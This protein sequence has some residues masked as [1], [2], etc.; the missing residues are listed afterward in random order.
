[1]STTNTNTTEPE[2]SLVEAAERLGIS[3]QRLR[4][5]V[6]K[7]PKDDRPRTIKAFL[8]GRGRWITMSEFRRFA[9]LP[10]KVGH[11]FAKPQG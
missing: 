7:G 5:L 4:Q 10:V 9:K 3:P 11:P 8:R 2:I 6:Y 1:M